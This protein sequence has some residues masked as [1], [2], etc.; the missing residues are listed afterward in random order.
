MR[1]VIEGDRKKDRQDRKREDRWRQK[2]KKMRKGDLL[3]HN[4]EKGGNCKRQK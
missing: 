4:R 3:L 1:Q 2:E